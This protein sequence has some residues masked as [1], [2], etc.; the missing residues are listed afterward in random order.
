MEEL[1]IRD[2]PLRYLGLPGSDLLDLEV[3]AAICGDSTVRF[4]YLG[5]NSATQR[6]SEATMQR[7]A[8]NTLRANANVDSQ[9]LLLADD[10][11]VLASKRSIAYSRL[12]DFES[13]D[14]VNLD[15]CDAFTSAGGK[16]IHLAVQNVVEYQTNSRTQPW[17]LFITTTVD[18]R[19]IVEPEL[20]KYAA[21][22]AE[23]ATDSPEFGTQLT[24]LAGNGDVQPAQV[25]SSATGDR[26]ARLLVLA[27]GKWLHGVICGQPAWTIELKSSVYYRW[28]ITGATASSGA[29]A[30]GGLVSAV[31]GISRDVVPASDPSG[32]SGGTAVHAGRDANARERRAALQMVKKVARTIDLDCL[33]QEDR[34]LRETLTREAAQMLASRN[35]DETKYKEYAASVVRLQC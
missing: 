31:Y 8:D 1:E 29:V 25:F 16:P 34:D 27:M 24:E 20:G 9:S 22:L 11:S 14:V 2:R 10:F 13:F 17:L 23:N 35:Y 28:G 12:R 33:L 26:L 19:V 21:L 6:A 32:I 30:D 7:I 5:L 18:R 15:L 4:R 3:L